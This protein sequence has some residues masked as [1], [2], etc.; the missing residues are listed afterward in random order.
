MNPGSM[1]TERYA[2]LLDDDRKRNAERFEAAFYSS[3][4]GEIGATETNEDSIA[5]DE[6][7]VSDEAD[8][9]EA[10]LKMLEQSPEMMALL[11]A[12]L[13]KKTT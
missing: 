5:D 9:R 8:E 3:G 7:A 11:K 1:V 13:E 12:M 10:L 4:S 6:S 2:H